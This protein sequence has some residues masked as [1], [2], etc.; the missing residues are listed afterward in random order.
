MKFKEY[1][2]DKFIFLCINFIIFFILSSILYNLN[3]NKIYILL[4]FILWFCPLFS[5]ILLEYIKYKSYFNKINETL[6]FLDKKY[7][8]PEV[9]ESTNYF[10]TEQINDILKIISRDMHENIN[11]YKKNRNEY[12]EYIETWVHE[13]KTPI[14]SSKLIIENNKNEITKTIDIQLEKIEEFVEQVLYYSKIDTLE[15]DY[16]IKKNNLKNIILNVIKKNSK[17][18]ILNK[19]QLNLNVIDAIIYTDSKWLEFILN[20][21]ISNCLKYKKS[22][23]PIINIKTN[24][25][26]NHIILYIEDNGI[27]ICEKD[28]NKVFE[29]GFTGYNGRKFY[30]STGIGL[31]LCK[32]LCD[33]LNIIINISSKENIETKVELIF[34]LL[35]TF[36]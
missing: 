16:I 21:I 11:Y 36:K 9:I 7:L 19:V 12:K 30:K 23:N 34:P 2:E 5:Y 35:D 26:K 3:I 27:G 6:N 32:K 13:I 8:L 20:Q 33:K 15:K 18:F 22:K 31:Y 25:F 29:K 24:K 28:I 1:I 17:E 4:L 14:S 10:L